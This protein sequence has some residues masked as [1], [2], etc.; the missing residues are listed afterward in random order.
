MD[1]AGWQGLNNTDTQIKIDSYF[2]NSDASG[3][4]FTHLYAN[5]G[6]IE[7]GYFQISRAWRVSMC[8]DNYGRYCV[9]SDGVDNCFPNSFTRFLMAYEISGEVTLSHPSI[10][11]ML[12][13]CRWARAVVS[14]R[15]ALDWA[16]SLHSHT[17]HL[18]LSA[19]ALS[20]APPV[21]LVCLPALIQTPIKA[22]LF[23]QLYACLQS[24]K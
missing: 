9:P 1:D 16:G 4:Q 24:S 8:V 21:S 19:A 2:W 12:P 11:Y 22:C 18:H 20:G 17:F 15:Q 14:N 3:T 5:I 10:C 6:V 23:T 7:Q 13:L